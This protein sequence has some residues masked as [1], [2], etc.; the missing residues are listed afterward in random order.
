MDPSPSRER[1]QARHEDSAALTQQ[2]AALSGEDRSALL[3]RVVFDVV[4][5]VLGLDASQ[6][7]P[8]YQPLNELGLDSLLAIDITRAL[9]KRLGSRLPGD[10]LL[11]APSVEDIAFYI[12]NNLGTNLG[13]R[14]A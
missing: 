2:L 4:V 14:R 1:A 8:P 10:L 5:R 13:E 7:L 3:S 11:N 6:A 9:E 12:E